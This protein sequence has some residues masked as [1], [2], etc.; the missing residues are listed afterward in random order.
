MGEW[1]GQQVVNAT[2]GHLWVGWIPWGPDAIDIT[3][4]IES[5]RKLCPLTEEIPMKYK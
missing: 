3:S 1:N 5:M 2:L 4:G